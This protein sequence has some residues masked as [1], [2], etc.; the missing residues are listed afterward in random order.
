MWVHSFAFNLLFC[1]MSEQNSR[2]MLPFL[3][4]LFDLFKII[5]HEMSIMSYFLSK[6]I[7][8]CCYSGTEGIQLIFF[9]IFR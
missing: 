2:N 9:S 6:F 7:L 4:I 5:C 8:L 3:I 1:D